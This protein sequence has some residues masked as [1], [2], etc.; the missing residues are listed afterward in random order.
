MELGGT[1]QE[2][3][4]LETNINAP[5]IDVNNYGA[6]TVCCGLPAQRRRYRKK[7]KF[8]L[9]RIGG[10]IYFRLSIILSRSI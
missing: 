8:G 3:P 10:P 6:Q 4:H 7:I 1:A 5:G 9:T 2:Q